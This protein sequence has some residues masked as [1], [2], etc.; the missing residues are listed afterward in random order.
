M[1]LLSL[2]LVFFGGLGRRR[3]EERKTDRQKKKS[4]ENKG[5]HAFLAGL[6]SQSMTQSPNHLSEVS[7]LNDLRKPS[8]TAPNPND[9]KSEGAK[10]AA[11][12]SLADVCCNGASGPEVSIIAGFVC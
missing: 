12:A 2:S 4:R 3:L 7:E 1:G 5:R 8:P 11:A 6:A 10:R 9:E